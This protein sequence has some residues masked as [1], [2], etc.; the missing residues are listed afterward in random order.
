MKIR[1]RDGA[2]R[3]DIPLRYRAPAA[4][5]AQV[6]ANSADT[7]IDMIAIERALSGE[8]PRPKLRVLEAHLAW[9]LITSPRERP[10]IGRWRISSAS[11]IARSSGGATSRPGPSAPT[12]RPEVAR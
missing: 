4:V 12:R 1:I 7:V 9:S 8:M 10:R 2:E 11:P 5:T 3:V 6:T